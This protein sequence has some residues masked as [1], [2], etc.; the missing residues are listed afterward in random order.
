MYDRNYRTDTIQMK[1]TFPPWIPN[2]SKLGFISYQS[3]STE[4]A[5]FIFD[6]CAEANPKKIL[7]IGTGKGKST[8][9]LLAASDCSV[10]TL[11]K[12][13]STFQDASEHI[14]TERIIKHEKTSSK[15][16]FNLTVSRNIDF[17]FIDATLY[18]FEIP[19]IFLRSPTNFTVVLHD[20]WI[21]GDTVRDE[22][23]KQNYDAL[24]QFALM[25]NYSIEEHYGAHCCIE[26]KFSHELNIV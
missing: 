13:D 15:D 10:I 2:W 22:K 23:G 19:H 17:W 26:L 21:D 24:K 12:R 6:S 16:Y 18:L 7:E 1:K 3:I 9:C 14:D 25:N 4:D 8:Y 5:Q 11:D 20:Y